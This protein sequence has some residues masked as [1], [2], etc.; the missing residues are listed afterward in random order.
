MYSLDKMYSLYKMWEVVC[1][2]RDEYNMH[3][4]QSL[5]NLD[6]NDYWMQVLLRI[7]KTYVNH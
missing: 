3:S 2:P 1:S 6:T 4:K 7:K 5:D